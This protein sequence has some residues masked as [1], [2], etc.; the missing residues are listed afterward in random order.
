MV[1]TALFPAASHRLKPFHFSFFVLIRID[2]YIRAF[3]KYYCRQC[4]KDLEDGYGIRR[5]SAADYNDLHNSTRIRINDISLPYGGKFD[6]NGSWSGGHE[7]HRSGR[8]TDISAYG[9]DENNDRVDINLIQMRS[10]IRNRTG[11]D[12]LFHDPPHFHVYSR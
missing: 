1:E 7:A 12:P 3:L 8:N 5:N 11:I 9:V 2:S 6:I 4:N 10:I